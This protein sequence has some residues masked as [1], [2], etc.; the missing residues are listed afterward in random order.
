M[1]FA[2][3][4][5]SFF[6]DVN[7]CVT[8]YFMYG[9]SHEGKYCTFNKI[10][11]QKAQISVKS[12]LVYSSVSQKSILCDVCMCMY[13]DN[14]QWYRSDNLC[15]LITD[16]WRASLGVRDSESCWF[17]GEIGTYMR[18][19]GSPGDLPLVIYIFVSFRS[20]HCAP[21]AKRHKIS[22]TRGR[23]SGLSQERM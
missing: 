11:V 17:T 5:T 10:L 1:S 15:K 3:H 16:Q 20:F 8:L 12:Y 14:A 13:V 6:N 22:I 2:V 4:L 9:V 18:C 7:I 23:S 19:W 21:L